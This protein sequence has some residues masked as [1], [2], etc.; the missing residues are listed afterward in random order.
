VVAI[1]PGSAAA[2]PELEIGDLVRIL[3]NHAC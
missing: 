2:L 1:R 3:P